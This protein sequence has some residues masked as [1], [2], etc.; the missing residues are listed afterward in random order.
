MVQI[1][2]NSY[3]HRGGLNYSVV[4]RDC[5]MIEVGC[6]TLFISWCVV[7]AVPYRRAHGNLSSFLATVQVP[8]HSDHSMG[9]PFLSSHFPLSRCS[10]SQQVCIIYVLLFQHFLF[11]QTQISGRSIFLKCTIWSYE[12]PSFCYGIIDLLIFCSQLALRF[13]LA[14]SIGTSHNTPCH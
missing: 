2:T 5:D 10:N 12:I 9:A 8:D 3:L 13:S 6:V 7:T 4:T 1:A 11:H 14:I